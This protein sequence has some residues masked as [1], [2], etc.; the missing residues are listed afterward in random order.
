MSSITIRNLDDKLQASLR[1]RAV[2]H[3]LSMAHEDKA[4]DQVYDV[5]VGDRTTL[6][7]LFAALRDALNTSGVS[8]TA[9]PSYRDFRAGDVRPQPGRNWQGSTSV[10]LC[11]YTPN[12]RWDTRR[13]A[14]VCRALRPDAMNREIF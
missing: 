5:V 10:G 1:M 11:A 4:K 7:Q 8:P 2:L 3:G 9:Q 13:H 14:L 12:Y 6:N